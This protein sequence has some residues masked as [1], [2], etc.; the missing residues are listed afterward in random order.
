MTARQFRPFLYVILLLFAVF[1][2]TPVYVLLVTSLKSFAEVGLDR[3]WNLPSGLSLAS[4][5]KAWFGS[6]SEG[7]PGLSRNFMNSVY[8]AIPG[9]ILSA[10][11]GSINGY[12]L[13]KWKFRG[14]DVLF[15]LLL[16]GMFIPYQSV[17]IPLVQTVRAL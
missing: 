11:L 1:Y 13:S 9:T 14:A 5:G 3:M 2:L 12:I 8:L 16:F 7:A 10:I 15:P 17:L 4:F 6:P